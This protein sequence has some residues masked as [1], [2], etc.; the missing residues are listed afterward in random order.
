MSIST[1]MKCAAAPCRARN[2]DLRP[3]NTLIVHPRWFNGVRYDIE[4]RVH[5]GCFDEHEHEAP[6]S[7]EP[8]DALA[9]SHP[10]PR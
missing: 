8:V 5:T 1:P 10:R 6:R 3:D 9:D 4:L 7:T 2:D